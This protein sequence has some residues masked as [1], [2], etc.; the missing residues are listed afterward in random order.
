MYLSVKLVVR[1]EQKD[2][3]AIK[4][5]L[6]S[7]TFM[8]YDEVVKLNWVS[9][10]GIAVLTCVVK[11]LIV[12][13]GPNQILSNCIA[14]QNCSLDGRNPRKVVDKPAAVRD[15]GDRGQ[16]CPAALVPGRVLPM[17]DD[18][19]VITKRTEPDDV[20]GIR[21]EVGVYHPI[22]WP[23]VRTPA[24]WEI[25]FPRLATGCA[26]HIGDNLTKVLRESAPSISREI[27]IRVQE[28][29]QVSHPRIPHEESPHSR[30]NRD[31]EEPRGSPPPTPPHVRITY[32]AVRRIQ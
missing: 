30:H 25:E 6:G 13:N 10:R 7:A 18:P 16:P 24:A 4:S 23:V 8:L 22:A 29:S 3:P 2:R 12:V 31:R 14:G 5:D 21:F 32:A 15:P 28:V 9:K 27:A 1:L 19:P 17:V 11:E 20:G 26:R